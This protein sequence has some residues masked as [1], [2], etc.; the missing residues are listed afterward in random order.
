MRS[1]GV[2]FSKNSRSAFASSSQE[3]QIFTVMS[4]RFIEEYF[5]IWVPSFPRFGVTKFGQCR[6][7]RPRGISR[8]QCSHTRSGRNLLFVGGSFKLPLESIR[9]L[10]E[11]PRRCELI[12]IRRYSPP[13]TTAAPLQGGVAASSKKIWRSHR[14]RR[15]RGGFPF[16]F[17]GKPPRPRDKRMLR[18]I[19]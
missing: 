14:S 13:C 8:G 10:N 11:P 5:I 17:I 19:F 2:R 16:G 15:S 1:A 4:L 7:S 6:W 18:D 3:R 9:R 12:V